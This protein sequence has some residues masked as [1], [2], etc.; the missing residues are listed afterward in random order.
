MISEADDDSAWEEPVHVQRPDTAL[1]LP[2]D[3]MARAAFLAKLHRTESL[4]AWLERVN[5][6]DDVQ[7]GANLFL[8]R[9]STRL[10]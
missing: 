3:L 10:S 7:I 2:A 9:A 5:Q 1:Q 4:Y 6:R 8:T